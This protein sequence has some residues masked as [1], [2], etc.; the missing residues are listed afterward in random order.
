MV[1]PFPILIIPNIKNIVNEL[2]FIYN[3]KKQNKGSDKMKIGFLG[4][5]GTFSYEACCQYGIGNEFIEYK[6]IKETILGL[7][8]DEVSEVIVPI[9]NSLQGGVTETIDTL[10]ENNN[11]H[12]KKEIILKISHNLMA[13]SNYTFEEIKEV[14]S[15]PQALA[16]CRNYI[17]N[18]LKNA[19]IHQVSSTALAAKEIKNK[20]YCACIANKACVSEYE[21]VLLDKEIQDND[22]NQTKFWVLSKEENKLGDKMSIIFSTK[23][24]PGALYK[25]LGL[26]NEYDINLTKIESR[27]AKTVLGE[28]IFLVDIEVSSKIYEA[29][30]ILKEECSYLKILGRY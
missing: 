21:L 9:E 17:Q 30:E 10:I 25:I 24:K 12:I 13:N 8:N 15:H 14:Y 26:F 4:P 20:D 23:N 22:L 6:T 29:I 2:N 5:K 18:N 7:E 1:S 19:S 3:I 16:Q 27:P 11:I 28:Y